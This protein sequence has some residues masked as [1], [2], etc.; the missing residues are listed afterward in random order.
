MG[1]PPQKIGDDGE[2]S[3]RSWRYELVEFITGIPGLFSLCILGKTLLFS[4]G[5]I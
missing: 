5:H 2:Q 3:V 1:I 4:D